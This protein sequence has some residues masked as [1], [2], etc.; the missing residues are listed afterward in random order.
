M[1]FL[2]CTQNLSWLRPRLARNTD[3]N[4]LPSLASHHCPC[5]LAASRDCHH[6]HQGRPAT[7]LINP[8]LCCRCS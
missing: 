1:P 3:H 6:R 4:L 8:W 5:R 7:V 2:H